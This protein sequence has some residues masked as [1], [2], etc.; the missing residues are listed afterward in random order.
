MRILANDND[1][2]LLHY[3]YRFYCTRSWFRQ[4]R[5]R[6]RRSKPRIVNDRR[7]FMARKAKKRIQT[8]PLVSLSHLFKVWW[9]LNNSMSK[10][11]NQQHLND[12]KVTIGTLTKFEISQKHFV[13]LRNY[14]WT[15]KCPDNQNNKSSFWFTN[16]KGFVQIL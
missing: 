2:S 4:L 15:T 16:N 12:H 5:S 8:I 7:G 9:T 3:Q 11:F 1:V 6:Q 10:H 14:I 13:L